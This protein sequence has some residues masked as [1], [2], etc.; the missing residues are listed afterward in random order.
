MNK[1][2]ALGGPRNLEWLPDYGGQL[3]KIPLP[4]DIRVDWLDEPIEPIEP[5][6]LKTGIYYRTKL[7]WTDQTEVWY[8]DVYLFEGMLPDDGISILK[9]WLL[10]AFIR[11]DSPSDDN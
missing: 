10:G 11:M 6:V 7:G 3:I 9:E 2:I 4:F 1:L 8:K 5:T